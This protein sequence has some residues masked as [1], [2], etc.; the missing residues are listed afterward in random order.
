MFGRLKGRNRSTQR[1][2]EESINENGHTIYYGINFYIDGSGLDCLY[3]WDCRMVGQK[4]VEE[5][6]NKTIE[7]RILEYIF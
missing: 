2:V 4:M 5:Q 3:S 6:M 7:Q 1:N